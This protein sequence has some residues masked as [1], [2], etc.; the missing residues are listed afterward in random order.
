MVE[1]SLKASICVKGF[2]DAIRPLRCAHPHVEAEAMDV[3]DS[4]ILH[5]GAQGIV[6]GWKVS[7][8]LHCP[9]GVVILRMSM[10]PIVT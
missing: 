9:H 4:S 1:V 2:V 5:V 3:L 10:G 8:C 7:I 6:R